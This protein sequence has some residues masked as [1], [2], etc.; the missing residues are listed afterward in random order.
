MAKFSDLKVGVDYA[1][2]PWGAAESRFTSL[3]RATVLEV[4]AARTFH[5][6]GRYYRTE[7]KRADGVRVRW[8]PDTESPSSR[9]G[10]EEVLPLQRIGPEWAE[11]VEQERRNTE[12]REQRAA[13]SKQAKRRA[14]AA[15]AFLKSKGIHANAFDGLKVT[16]EDLARLLALLGIPDPAAEEQP[17]A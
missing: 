6:G 15:A 11:H 2:C 16:G 1:V 8:I 9:D 10:M 12:Y 7:Q 5:P 3:Y 14:E 4:R 13:A 17:S